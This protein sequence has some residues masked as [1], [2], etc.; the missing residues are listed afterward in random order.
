MHSN[1]SNALHGIEHDVDGE[2]DGDRNDYP[3]PYP[4]SHSHT[5][6]YAIAHTPRGVPESMDQ[7]RIQANA[8]TQLYSSVYQQSQSMPFDEPILLE[9]QQRATSTPPSP[10]LVP[11]GL[12][13]SITSLEPPPNPT[14]L[15]HLDESLESLLQ[16]PVH[17][18]PSSESHLSTQMLTYES[19]LPT[20]PRLAPPES[21][22]QHNPIYLSHSYTTQVYSHS[23]TS[24]GMHLLPTTPPPHSVPPA[25][26]VEPFSGSSNIFVDESQLLL[27]EVNSQGG[28]DAESTFELTQL[29]PEGSG[30]DLVLPS[31]GYL[32]EALSFIAAER[33]KW[34]T[35]RDVRAPASSELVADVEDVDG[36]E[37]D[38]D[39]KH[40]IGMS[41]YFYSCP[42]SV[43]CSL[44]I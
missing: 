16:P 38:G 34:T 44:T 25:R 27:G 4:H 42:L 40:G 3:Y 15:R 31:L 39:W 7:P 29:H 35:A 17:E 23:R 32:D 5:P 24:A 12:N 18:S 1:R 10:L 13:F 2:V 21:Q 6:R 8:T 19:S 26:L 37:D 9:D 36:E 11:H 22:L 28:T 41:V 14:A 33:T 20:V 43:L 30:D